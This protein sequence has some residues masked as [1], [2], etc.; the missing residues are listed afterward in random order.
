MDSTK[1]TQDMK[2]HFKSK[3]KNRQRIR[4]NEWVLG[5]AK[6][7]YE[8]QKRLIFAYDYHGLRAGMQYAPIVIL[9]AETTELITNSA[10]NIK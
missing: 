7:K 6:W 9:K 3:G 1:L 4:K 5:Y 10:L 8:I 2:H